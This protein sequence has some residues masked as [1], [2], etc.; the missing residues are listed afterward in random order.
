M[1]IIAPGLLFCF[2]LAVAAWIMSKIEGRRPGQYGL[3]RSE[4]LRKNFRVGL[5]IVLLATSS[6]VLAIFAPHG[7]RFTS[8]G[9][10]WHRVVTYRK[11][12][13]RSSQSPTFKHFF[14][15]TLHILIGQSSG[16]KGICVLAGGVSYISGNSRHFRARRATCTCTPPDARPVF[17]W[18]FYR[19]PLRDWAK[20]W[21]SGCEVRL[22]KSG[23]MRG[24]VSGV[25]HPALR[26]P[27]DPTLPSQQTGAA[28]VTGDGKTAS[29][30]WGSEVG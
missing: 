9:D 8:G 5:L 4:A 29:A 6:T 11:H 1:R 16:R 18:Q 2:I 28:E 26:R 10:P 3:P 14:V 24:Y 17:G 25:E 23:R 15:A 7:V 21:G 30:L 20:L 12:T 27:E 13:R 19:R 22:A